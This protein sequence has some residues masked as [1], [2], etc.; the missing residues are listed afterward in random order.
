MNLC[1]FCLT[2][3]MGIILGDDNVGK[4]LD[5]GNS[6]DEMS[7]VAKRN[8]IFSVSLKP[9]MSMQIPME[10]DQGI[11]VSKSVGGSAT[12]SFGT[13]R[14]GGSSSLLLK[15]SSMSMMSASSKMATHRSFSTSTR[16]VAA[17]NELS[18][19]ARVRIK[20]MS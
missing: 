1:T 9:L 5:P 2:R 20:I 16:T 11:A 19:E 10:S 14:L 18:K 12:P 6:I 4:C 7:A 3:V 15:G 17:K 13:Q 8:D